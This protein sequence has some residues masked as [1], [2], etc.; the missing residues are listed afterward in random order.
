MRR[1]QLRLKDMVEN[2]DAV[3]LALAGKSRSDFD[4]DLLL[5]SA[6]LHFIQT[7]GEAASRASVEIREKYPDVPWK[8]IG[9]TRNFIVH[10]Y[11]SVDF[12][13]I[14]QT[15]SSDL[16]PLRARIAEILKAEFPG[17]TALG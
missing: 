2:I 14:W 8:N 9:D 4:N 7:I 5:R 10:A 3:T 11:F 12:D 13:L 16:L 15:I 1:D 6:V 17:G